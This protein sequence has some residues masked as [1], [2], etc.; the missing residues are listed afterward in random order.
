MIVYR[1]VHSIV[2][3]LLIL[4][5]GLVLA[6]DDS[7]SGTEVHRDVKGPLVTEKYSSDL[8]LWVDVLKREDRSEK[9]KEYI[10]SKRNPEDPSKAE[11]DFSADVFQ[12]KV[13]KYFIPAK[14]TFSTTQHEMGE[15]HFDK[16]KLEEAEEKF[17][18]KLENEE[19]FLLTYAK[20]S[21]PEVGKRGIMGMIMVPGF[22]YYGIPGQVTMYWL[23]EDAYPAF[24]EIK[25]DAVYPTS[26]PGP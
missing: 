11:P 12:V 14:S 8:F 4:F 10:E 17:K 3:L 7:S 20:G 5:P 2:I 9:V 22:A 21:G 26:I 1:V 6:N 13:L 19:S 18:E 16:K 15:F 24:K 25:M 23:P